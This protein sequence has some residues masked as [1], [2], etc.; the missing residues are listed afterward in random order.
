[1]VDLALRPRHADAPL[2]A[3]LELWTSTHRSN[4]HPHN[5]IDD[6]LDIT[7]LPHD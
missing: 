1:M 4:Q 5:S 6:S 7:T 2:L 3:N